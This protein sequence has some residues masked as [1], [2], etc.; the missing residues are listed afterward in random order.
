MNER[1]YA[2]DDPDRPPPGFD[3]ARAAAR[4]AAAVLFAAPI[5]AATLLLPQPEDVEVAA[6]AA[7][8]GLSVLSGLALLLLDRREEATDAVATISALW[9]VAL[10]GALVAA[11]GGSR[12]VYAAFYVFPV[13]HAAA[14]GSRRRWGLVS[15]TAVLA[16][17]APVLYDDVDDTFGV[18]AAVSIPPALL[19]GLVLNLATRRLAEERAALHSRE[20]AALRLADEDPLTGLSNYRVFWRQ[21]QAESSRVRRHGGRF[22]L[23]LIDLDGFKAV[24]DERGHTAGDRVL[25]R[26]AD[27]LR[28][29][30]RTEDVLCRQGGDEFA[31][32]AV[33]AGPDEAAE[34]AERLAHAV[35]VAPSDPVREPQIGASAGHA[36][37][38]DDAN[39]AEELVARAD[40][41]LR[42]AKRRGRA[43]AGALPATEPVPVP[44][45]LA[46][47]PARE[48]AAVPGLSELSALSRALATAGN[49]SEVASIAV[50][51]VAGALDS[52][53][54]ALLRWDRAGGALELAA[55][56]GRPPYGPDRRVSDQ[57]G[58]L[59]MVVGERRAVILDDPQGDDGP[60]ADPAA[61]EA[62][63]ELAAPVMVG[64]EV[65]G[66]LHVV[67]DRA[68]AYG[69]AELLLAEAMAEQ[70]GR[71]LAGTWV[72]GRLAG[73]HNS[74]VDWLA[75][76]L[77]DPHSRSRRVADLAERVGRAMGLELDALRELRFSA[78]FHDIGTIGVPARV[79]HK[80]ARLTSEER[81]VVR[82]HVVLGER[83][84]R[85]VPQLREA[86][87]IVRHA[88]ERVDG[89][90][91]PDGLAG[92]QIP[93]GS[94]IVSA[95]DAYV[96]MTSPRPYRP[97]LSSAEALGELRRAAGRQLDRRV[98]DVLISVLGEPGAEPA[99][100]DGSY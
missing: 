10:V 18:L 26:T 41:A 83:M 51:H 87:R 71:A 2:R 72:L 61:V 57:A 8:G 9:M 12:S 40:E 37:F 77:E 74:Q 36:T 68:G 44:E 33:Q 96:A 54:T 76:A 79:L 60:L 6:V 59:G 5:L 4:S 49:A 56:S 17:L 30:V 63:S 35:R 15:A 91:Y 66:A 89:G 50:A 20:Q 94:R 16:F 3:E 19:A 52:V 86:A 32:I 64:E 93:L 81:A 100:A 82:E 34:L 53:G 24:N 45:D 21:L 67:C 46:G 73:A 58:L 85:R 38:G 62:R 48:P 55:Y 1:E 22:S 70:V 39:T 42:L 97:A 28:A 84:L 90:G 7:L 98:V 11:T 80:P 43:A 27:A 47:R 75:A 95:C 14:F 29:T 69:A 78:L 65:W 23:V 92:E 99:G 31:V 25:Q 88:H 13:V